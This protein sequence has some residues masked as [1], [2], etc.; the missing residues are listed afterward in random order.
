M[1]VDATGYNGLALSWVWANLANNGPPTFNLAASIG[2][3]FVKLASYTLPTVATTG[4]AWPAGS[5]I[6]YTLPAEYANKMVVIRWVQTG[7]PPN[8]AGG[9]AFFD[10]F[11]L[12]GTAMVS[13]ELACPLCSLEFMHA[14]VLREGPRQ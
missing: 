5:K 9:R 2:N 4:A 11:E 13:E 12:T 3:G 6:D 14:Y 1:T 7:F 10:N 8:S